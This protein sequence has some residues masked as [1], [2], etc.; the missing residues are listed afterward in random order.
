MME[1]SLGHDVL[2]MCVIY[3]SEFSVCCVYKQE[4][5]IDALHQIWKPRQIYFRMQ[6][7][8]SYVGLSVANKCTIFVKKKKALL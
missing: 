1:A 4:Q 3:L 6:N 7:I 5:F 2:V 8:N